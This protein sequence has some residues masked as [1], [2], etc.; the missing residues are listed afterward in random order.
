MSNR[1]YTL[2]SNKNE[3]NKKDISE[4]NILENN[5]I[6][7]NI[8]DNLN[9]EAT[10]TNQEN[11]TEVVKEPVIKTGMVYGCNLLNVRGEA[12]KDGTKLAVLTKN[13]TVEIYLDE[14]KDKYYKVKTNSDIYGY[15]LKEYI[16]IN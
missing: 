14:S 7:N 12:S 9:E 11:E 2:F 13:E 4:N 8:T 15:C 6:E 3:Q 5:E 16:K 1:N 10:N